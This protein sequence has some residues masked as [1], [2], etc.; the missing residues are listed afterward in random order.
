MIMPDPF[1]ARLALIVSCLC[2]YD[3]NFTSTALVTNWMTSLNTVWL[4]INVKLL[5]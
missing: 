5:F 4:Q 2:L 3:T 1:K